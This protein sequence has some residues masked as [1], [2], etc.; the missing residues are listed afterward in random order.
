MNQILIYLLSITGVSTIAIWLGKIIIT[1]S[2]DFGIEKYKAALTKDIEDHK[3]ELAKLSL[4]HQVKFTKL[5]DERAEKI[6]ILYARVIE[7][8]KALIFSTTVFQG[9]EYINDTARDDA[10]TE[11][12]KE[13]IQ[14]L[15][16]DRIYFSVDTLTKFDSI[17]KESWEIILQMRKVRRYASAL[18]DFVIRE[19]PAPEIYYSE[20][21]LWQNANERTENKFNILKNELADEFR[22]LLSI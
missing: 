9:P 1:K 8:E 2:F 20:T 6:R 16:Y 19:R 13:L 22:N 21:D 4:E 17:I 14:Q 11:K 7:L 18:N 15:D 5:H 3:N 12:L 10:S